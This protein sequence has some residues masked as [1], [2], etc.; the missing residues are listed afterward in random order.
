MEITFGQLEEGWHYR[1]KEL[2]QRLLFKCN[3]GMSLTDKDT[4]V[5]IRPDVIVMPLITSCVMSGSLYTA[6]P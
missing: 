2:P 1:L 5:L 3:A 6:N 4:V